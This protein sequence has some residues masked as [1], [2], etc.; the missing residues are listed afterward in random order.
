MSDGDVMGDRRASVDALLEDAHE[1][2]SSED[3]ESAVEAF[4]NPGATPEAGML[5]VGT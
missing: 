4:W 2:P 1:A 5:G 3:L